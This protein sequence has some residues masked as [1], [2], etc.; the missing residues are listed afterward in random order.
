MTAI[1]ICVWLSFPLEVTIL[2]DFI[3]GQR[4]LDPELAHREYLE[5]PRGEIR[6]VAMIA[7]YCEC[8]GCGFYRGVLPAK[9]RPGPGYLRQ[10]VEI[11]GHL[12]LR[13]IL[14]YGLTW[15]NVKTCV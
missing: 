5:Y 10:S 14:A 6:A 8:Q 7:E 3:Y 13:C 11:N 9:V 2:M 1:E 15:T 12:N 4:H